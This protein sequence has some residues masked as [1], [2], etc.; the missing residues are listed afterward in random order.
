M[1]SQI[2]GWADLSHSHILA[3]QQHTSLP[4]PRFPD[5]QNG[6]GCGEWTPRQIAAEVGRYLIPPLDHFSGLL[7]GNFSFLFGLGSSIL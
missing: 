4:E 1:G 7:K 5:L 3:Q 6:L 2:T